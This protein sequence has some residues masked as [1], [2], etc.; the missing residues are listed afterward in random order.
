MLN[1]KIKVLLVD[2]HAVVR[3]GVRLMLSVAQDILV[4]GEAE[5]AE[6]AARLVR[7]QEFDVALVDIALAGQS[8]LDL[9]KRLRV[10][11]PT[12]AVLILSM[13]SEEVYAVRALKLGAA[14]YLT[15]SNSATTM[16]EAVRKAATG[17]KY[18]SPALVER[19]ANMIGNDRVIPHEALSD[20]ELEVLKLLALGESLVNIAKKLHLS[21]KTVTTHRTHILEKMGMS[22][23]T[24]LVRYA[25]EN[26]L[27]I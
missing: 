4:M 10:E 2:D 13:Y 25:L 7:K 1:K 23:N 12:L 8:G 18:L 5:T 3:N 11:K 26:G 22:S 24:A 21:P 27:L 17:G 9:L 16:I 15:K 20:R 14:G 19:L 6:Q